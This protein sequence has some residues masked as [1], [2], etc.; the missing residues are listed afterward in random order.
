MVE[1]IAN[2]PLAGSVPEACQSGATGIERAPAHCAEGGLSAGGWRPYKTYNDDEC[3]EKL[4]F[5][6]SP[7]QMPLSSRSGCGAVIALREESADSRS[8]FW[9][10]RLCGDHLVFGKVSRGN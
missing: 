3:R 1:L 6:G 10:N 4:L 9:P 7:F 8:G 2:C 5:H